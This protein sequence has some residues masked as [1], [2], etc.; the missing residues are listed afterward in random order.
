MTRRRFLAL[1]AA[2]LCG[3]LAGCFSQQV[4][5]RS[6]YEPT[7]DTLTKRADGYVC[8]A[9]KTE[10]TRS[11]SRDEGDKEYTVGLINVDK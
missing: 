4:I 8:G 2:I 6:F 7:K 3:A 5:E 11:G 1:C 10:T 9:I